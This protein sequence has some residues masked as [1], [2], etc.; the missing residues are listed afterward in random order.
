MGLFDHGGLG[1]ADVGINLTGGPGDAIVP[2][3]L[4]EG[5]GAAASGASAYSYGGGTTGISSSSLTT[6]GA[7]DAVSTSTL[8][9]GLKVTHT[10]SSAAGGTL[11]RVGVSIEN[12]SAVGVTDVRYARTLDWDVPPSHFSDDFTTIY[13]GTPAGPAGN[14][15]HTSFDPF[16]VP[17]PMVLRG[18][19]GGVAANTNGTAV[20]GDLGAYFILGFG[21]LAA[22]ASVD[23][24]TYIGAAFTSSNLLGAFADVGIEAYS[25]TVDDNADVAY[26]WGFSDVGLPPV[27]GGVPTPAPLALMALG[28]LGVGASRR[29][30]R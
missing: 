17:D 16:A 26:G 25:F 27:F 30:R 20:P 14:V 2:G 11:F 23:F 8:S 29:A 3:C 15:L 13:G 6:S 9:N 24:T 21:D 5:W 7:A 28:I 10:Y 22:G 4:C 1:Y 18:T 19:Y 12:I